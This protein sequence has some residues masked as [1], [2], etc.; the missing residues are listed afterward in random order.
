MEIIGE[1][2]SN[3]LGQ[4]TYLAVTDSQIF[5]VIYENTNKYTISVLN[6]KESAAERKTLNYTAI[7]DYKVDVDSAKQETIDCEKGPKEGNCTTKNG[8]RLARSESKIG[9]LGIAL[10][11][12]GTFRSL[13]MEICK[14]H[15][16]RI[17]TL[18]KL[19]LLDG[20]SYS[21]VSTIAV[22]VLLLI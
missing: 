21:I 6:V 19:C 4:K 20:I 14:K 22:I 7:L 3:S 10:N 1:G 11:K 12:T 8:I 9:Y 15:I 5:I 16:L 18:F 2:I 17:P 13:P